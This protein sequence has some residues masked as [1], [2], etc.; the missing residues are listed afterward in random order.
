MGI[1][2]LMSDIENHAVISSAK[3]SS[4]HC[5]RVLVCLE[6]ITGF[7]AEKSCC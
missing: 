2:Y 5:R 4:F 7:G 3:K 1:E 6:Y